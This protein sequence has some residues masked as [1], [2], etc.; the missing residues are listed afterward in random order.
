MG[1]VAIPKMRE[2]Y[3]TALQVFDLNAVRCEFDDEALG[4]V[5]WGCP[6]R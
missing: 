2:V 6:S 3:Q 1:R 5:F 4:F